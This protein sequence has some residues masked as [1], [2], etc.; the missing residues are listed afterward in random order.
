MSEKII[1]KNFGGLKKVEF[2]LRNINILIGPQASGKSVAVKL[3]YFFKKFTSEMLKSLENGDNKRKF[4]KKQKERFTT[5]FPKESWPN[6][7]FLIEYRIGNNW[8]VVEKQKNK[9]LVFAYSEG[10]RKVFNKGKKVFKVTQKTDD[11]LY[12]IERSDYVPLFKDYVENEIGNIFNFGQ[13]F[14]PAG[15]SFFAN[16]QSNIFSFLSSNQSLDPFLVEFGS[17]YENLKRPFYV[18]GRLG[19]IKDRFDELTSEIINGKF[20]RE[21]VKDYI[22]HEDT[23][24]V[25]LANASSGQQETLPLTVVLK[26]LIDPMPFFDGGAVLYIE[27]PEAHLFPTAQKKIVQLLARTFNSGSKFQ[28]I[29]TTHSPYILSA[30]NNLIEAGKIVDEDASKEKAVNKVIP[31]EEAIKPKD[32]IAYSLFNGKKK[33]LIDKTTKLIAQ[34]ELDAVSDELSVEFGKLLDIEF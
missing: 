5:Y 26:A 6:D 7:S 23:R 31:K 30:F 18:K 14:I 8:I 34:N 32:I 28:I 24:K 25:N 21:G 15:R 29:I 10:Y 13:Y 20:Q 17:F 11:F 3:L 19:S 2:E 27:E 16:V 4:D 12:L 22:I 33:V 9:N 1:I